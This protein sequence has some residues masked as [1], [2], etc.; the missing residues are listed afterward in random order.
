MNW[1]ALVF[2]GVP[3]LE[4]F[5]LFRTFCCWE[6]KRTLFE[7]VFKFSNYFLFNF[8]FL[9]ILI[10][11]ALFTVTIWFFLLA[12][13]LCCCDLWKFLTWRELPN[14][15]IIIL[16]PYLSFTIN[17]GFGFNLWAEVL[18]YF[19]LN[20]SETLGRC[21]SSPKLFSIAFNVGDGASNIL[22]LSV[23]IDLLLVNRRTLL[24]EAHILIKSFN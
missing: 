4:N 8:Y 14:D 22:S 20:L 10:L 18:L 13:L 21:R 1:D 7:L 9:I 15:F 11:F 6:I 5:K 19:A 12:I 2:L 24:E 17:T 23:E 3:S 16:S